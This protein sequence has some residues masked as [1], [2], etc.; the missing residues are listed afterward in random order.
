MAMAPPDRFDDRRREP[1][2]PV[3]LD[4]RVYPGALPCIVCDRSASGA[5]LRFAHSV[6][7]PQVIIVVFWR[8]GQA[9]ESQVMWRHGS[10]AGLRFLRGADLKGMVPAAFAPAKAAWTGR[11]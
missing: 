7:L 3:E 11:I 2:I 5:R 6:V 4:A 10:E 9:H 8:S 1:R